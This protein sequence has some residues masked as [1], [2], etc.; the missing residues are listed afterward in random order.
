VVLGLDAA[1]RRAVAARAGADGDRVRAL[2]LAI[3]R[4]ADA[5]SSSLA[6][7][8]RSSLMRWPL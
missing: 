8:L 4:D 2:R 5:V 1:C 6:D 3:A 7:D